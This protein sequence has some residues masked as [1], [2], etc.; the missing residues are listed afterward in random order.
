MQGTRKRPASL[1]K[2]AGSA[3]LAKPASNSKLEG[4]SADKEKALKKVQ[5]KPASNSK[6]TGFSAEKQRAL[7]KVKGDGLLLKDVPSHLKADRDVV[8]AAVKDHGG[9]LR[10]AAEHLKSDRKIVSAAVNCFSPG[11]FAACADA[12]KEDETFEVEARKEFYWFRIVPPSGLSFMVHKY[13]LDLKEVLYTCE[14]RLGIH[15]KGT[16]SLLYGTEIV[17]N[18]EGAHWPG[19][20][21]MGAVVEYKLVL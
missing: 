4:F 19:A 9:A 2:P 8:M 18:E 21:R 12:L 15:F 16:A 6:L 7:K 3:S 1:V 17:P 5:K 10:F 20:P 13:N 14:R 11:A